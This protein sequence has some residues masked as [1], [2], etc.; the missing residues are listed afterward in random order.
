MNVNY[1]S[2][3]NIRYRLQNVDQVSTSSAYFG[4]QRLKN[5]V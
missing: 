3:H 5:Y 2:C 4:E 1:I